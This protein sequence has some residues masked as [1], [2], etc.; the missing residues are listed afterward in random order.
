MAETTLLIFDGG[1]LIPDEEPIVGGD[2]PVDKKYLKGR[3]VGAFDDTDEEAAFTPTAQ[4]PASYAGGTLKATLHVIFASATSGAA[5]F[6]VSVEA[7][8][9]GDPHDLDAGRYFD[10]VNSGDVNAPGTAGYETSG[11]SICRASC[12]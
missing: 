4:M 1:S 11:T 7:I 10:S 12:G 2:L 6:D 3:I 8:T 5:R 9:P